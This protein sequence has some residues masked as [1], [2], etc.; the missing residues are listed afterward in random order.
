MKTTMLFSFQLRS[1]HVF[2]DLAKHLEQHKYPIAT[3]GPY[4]SD[5]SLLLLL[6]GIG[7]T[8]PEHPKDAICI[9]QEAHCLAI[10][11]ML[12]GNVPVT[13]D[14]FRKKLLE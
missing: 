4:E 3:P 6:N 8:C 1:A 10:M 11:E 7:H 5:A 12:N 14:A 2:V 9:T 13:Q